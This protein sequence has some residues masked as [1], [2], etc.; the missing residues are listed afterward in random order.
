MHFMRGPMPSVW[1]ADFWSR[2][3]DLE[4]FWI[5]HETRISR[6]SSRDADLADF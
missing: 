4:D 6:I 5:S 2:D 3:A 1:D